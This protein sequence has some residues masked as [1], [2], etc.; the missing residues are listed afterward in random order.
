MQHGHGGAGG[1]LPLHAVAPRRE[2]GACERGL[3][4]T[5]APEVV[6][7]PGP[8]PLR[9]GASPAVE[10]VREQGKL[11]SAH[12]VVLVRICV[13]E[14]A[15]EVCVRGHGRA[16]GDTPVAA[17]GARG[18]GGERLPVVLAPAVHRPHEAAGLSLRLGV[19]EHPGQREDV[20]VLLRG[21]EEPGVGRQ[22]PHET[23]ELVV[24]R[25]LPPDAPEDVPRDRS[26][27]RLLRGRRIV[28]KGE[29]GP[30]IGPAV[31][32]TV[33]EQILLAARQCRLGAHGAVRR[34]QKREV[35]CSFS[36]LDAPWVQTP[37]EAVEDLLGLGSPATLDIV[38]GRNRVLIR[39]MPALV[40]PSAAGLWQLAQ[41][42]AG[43]P[44]QRLLA[45][46]LQ[47]S[48]APGLQI[49]HR[50]DDA[51]ACLLVRAHWCAIQEA[52]RC[53]CPNIGRR[54]RWRLLLWRRRRRGVPAVDR[55]SCDSQAQP[56][57][58]GSGAGRRSCC[59]HGLRRYRGCAISRYREHG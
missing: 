28:R 52:Q 55:G 17:R 16:A 40:G 50:V 8:E 18:A 33:H 19:P 20:G 11:Q 41:L 4:R 21:S 26:V 15:Q 35:A 44:S 49:Q 9:R 5:S 6:D 24:A 42:P 47:Q 25:S 27:A 53:C 51:E 10:P 39:V 30:S 1:D 43:A 56:R 23:P 37:D 38:D 58:V 57:V 13:R 46:L 12:G 36:G 29:C 59:C 7:I 32:V 14:E 2:A 54:R 22:P 48:R 31:H 45:A 3:C 34:R